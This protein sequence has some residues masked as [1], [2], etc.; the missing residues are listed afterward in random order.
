MDARTRSSILR[1]EITLR[2]VVELLQQRKWSYLCLTAIMTLAAAIAS[3]VLPETFRATIIVSPVANAPGSSGSGS[4]V[5][6]VVSQFSNLASLAGLGGLGPDTR[7]YEAVALLQSET[8]TE[9]YIRTNNLLPVLYPRL[10]DATAGRWK[11]SDPS[12]I[13]TV[14]KATQRFKR[15][16]ANVITD[17]KTGLVTLTITWYDA[18]QA[19]QWANGLV[20]MT[21]DYERGK[22][23][24]ESDRN[25]T[26][27]NDQTAKTD[28]VGVK[29]AVSS[30]LQSEISKEMLARGS[31]EYALKVIDH[32]VP[33]EEP[34]MPQPLMWTLI[35]F[36]SGLL[37]SAISAF[38]S[39][40]W[41][42]S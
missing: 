21:N 29:Q 32:A 41:S 1:D 20:K 4:G 15:H 23:I 11:S 13:P 17:T 33:P 35:G 3:W 9:D 31:D 30:L 14:W 16:I 40:A 39:V 8:I 24:V 37:I 5:G 26:Y 19:A 22:A 25:I 42:R 27:L 2:D 38:V 7:K 34:Y 6:S 12:D 28:L 10:W 36:G 18:Q